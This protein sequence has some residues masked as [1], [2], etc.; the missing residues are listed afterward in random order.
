VLSCV[1]SMSMMWSLYCSCRVHVF[2]PLQ[3]YPSTQFVITGILGP[4]SNAHGPNEFLHIDFTKK[5]TGCVASILLD[6]Y[7]ARTRV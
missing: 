6:H 7:Q 4:S 2:L 5:L 3:L 1:E